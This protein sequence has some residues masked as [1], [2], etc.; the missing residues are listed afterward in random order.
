MNYFDNIRML[1]GNG[2]RLGFMPPPKYSEDVLALFELMQLDWNVAAHTPF[3]RIKWDIFAA[4]FTGAE[5]M[6]FSDMEAYCNNEEF[7]EL[8]Q[9]LCFLKTHGIS[10]LLV[11]IND[12]LWRYTEIADRC[13][14]MRK[15]ILTTVL[16]KRRGWTV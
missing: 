3:E 15:G 9:V 6:V 10:L 14:V 4:Y 5:I 8:E 16:E 1:S 12:N 2:R 13:L 11:A 7:D